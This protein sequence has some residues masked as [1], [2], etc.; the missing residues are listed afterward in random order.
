MDFHSIIGNYYGLDWLTLALGVAS[1]FLI[2]GG[3]LR[4]GFALGIVACIAAFAVATM[5]GQNGFMVYNALLA[6]LNLRGVL[7]G[8]RRKPRKLEVPVAND[9]AALTPQ[10]VAVR[11]HAR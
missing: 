3:K 6:G 2:T 9:D 10:A 8:D 5:S 4:T 7:R 1:S 11:V